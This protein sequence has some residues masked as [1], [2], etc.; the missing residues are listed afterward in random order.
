MDFIIQIL[1]E[2]NRLTKA[3]EATLVDNVAATVPWLAPVIPAWLAYHNMI[4]VLIMPA[5]VALIGALV[6]E[7]LGLATVTTT[8]QFR[9]FNDT[10]EDSDPGAPVLWA[11]VTAAFYL[12]VVL[13][14]NV[15]LDKGSALEKTAKAL[16][17][18]LSVAGAVTIALRSQHARRL[19]AKQ[20]R[21]ADD[22]KQQEK[23]REERKQDRRER[24]LQEHE[25][26]LAE[27]SAQV[28]GQQG[29]S[30][31]V[32]EGSAV[33]GKF[34]RWPDLPEAEKL[35]VAA[36]AW[37]AKATGVKTWKRDVMNDLRQVYGIEERS[38]YQWIDYGMRD[39]S[40][41][42]LANKSDSE[43]EVIAGGE[44]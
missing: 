8:V 5:E 3:L 32:S 11:I 14:V 35:K 26:R 41:L 10:R 28:A 42:N 13:T 21:I 30:E 2:W 7:F 1:N 22:Q 34:R 33:F 24:K 20:S 6:V 27:I 15:L 43:L 16:L 17:S 31:Q 23:R 38:G 29:K 4:K 19:T 39:Y 18:T 12:S 40:A 36:L 37:D 25:L 44:R 9:E